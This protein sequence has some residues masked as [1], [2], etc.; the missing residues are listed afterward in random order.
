MKHILTIAGSDSC[1][2][3]GIQADL[4]TIS[5]LGGYGLSVI[6]AVTAQNT[7]GVIGIQE[8]KPE[9][10]RAQLEAVFSDVRIDAIKIGM[11]G[12]STT[13]R[14]VAAF[15]NEVYKGKFAGVLPYHESGKL[16]LVLDPVMVAKSGDRLLEDEAVNSMI[17]DLLPLATV[18]TPNLPETETLLG[19]KITQ[20]PEMVR[21][22]RKL[23]EMGPKWVVV[24]GGHL[25]GE[26]V[27]IVV[28][29]DEVHELPGSRIA[30]NNNHGTGC[31]F[32]SAIATGLALGLP[33][34]EAICRAKTYVE[35]SL[36]HGFSI[37][38]GVGVLDHFAW[39]PKS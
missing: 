31:T 10:I 2:G 19:C 3:A 30:G 26:P 37:G 33:V 6:T 29:P 8:I 1:G 11:L 18:L 23:I 4:K 35:V 25:P 39:G 7:R 21:A 32:S 16:P 5:A 14:V 15:L 9:I 22:G 36:R 20:A 13:I 27:D 24:K 17:S 38:Q 34:N 12:S 28:G